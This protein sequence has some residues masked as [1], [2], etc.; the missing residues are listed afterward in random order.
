MADQ[1]EP[2]IPQKS[3]PVFIGKSAL[4]RLVN[5]EDQNTSSLWFI[6]STNKTLRPFMDESKFDDMFDNPQEAQ[7]AVVTL[8]S[9]ELGDGGILQDYEVLDNEYG[10][11]PDGKMKPIDFS[12]HQLG[13]RYGQPVDEV[14][15]TKAV[16]AL[17]QLFSAMGEQPQ[18]QGGDPTQEI[19]PQGQ[20]PMS[21]EQAAG[22]GGSGETGPEEGM[23]YYNEK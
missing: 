20:S 18:Q 4:V 5:A 21:P 19:P 16:S 23:I 9:N 10:I 1:K 13:Q 6:D 3:T 15:E 7:K 14:S 12:S 8:S 2:Q 11:E 22:I 17:D